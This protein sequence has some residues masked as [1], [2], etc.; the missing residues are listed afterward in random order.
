MI[1]KN[2]KIRYPNIN[3]Y[4]NVFY[5]FFLTPYFIKFLIQL[6]IML[7]EAKEYFDI[8]NEDLKNNGNGKMVFFAPAQARY[9]IYFYLKIKE[10]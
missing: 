2:I 1:K 10:D 3:L 4:L 7:P 5:S 9:F 8:I 6:T